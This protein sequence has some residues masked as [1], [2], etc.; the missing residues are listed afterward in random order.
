VNSWKAILAALV[1]FGA[2]LVTGAAWV[3]LSGDAK[4]PVAFAPPKISGNASTNGVARKPLSLEHLKKV[5]L[6]GSVQKEL[7]LTPEQRE[8]IEKVIGE[9]QDRIRDLWDRVAPE[10]D[11]EL[12]DVRKKLCAELTPEQNKRFDELM[13]QSKNKPVSP[14][15]STNAP[16]PA[17]KR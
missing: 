7:D 5:Q 2:G 14:A 3:K 10:I 13:K 15:V 17:E 1:I 12:K 4:P 11:D 9:G 16:A 8:R 6:M